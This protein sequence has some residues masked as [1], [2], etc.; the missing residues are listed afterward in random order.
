MNEIAFEEAHNWM[1]KVELSSKKGYSFDPNKDML[2]ITFTVICKA[3]FE[4]IPSEIEFSQFC[5]SLDI[6]LREFV[7]KQQINPFRRGLKYFI[8]EVRKALCHCQR[9]QGLAKR[10][11]DAYDEKPANERSLNKTLIRLIA[12]NDYLTPRDRIAEVVTFLIAGMDTT[13]CT[14]AS[15][16]VLLA[17]NPHVADKL[18]AELEACDPKEWSQC[19]YF[20]H[21]LQ[22]SYRIMPV[23]ALGPTRKVDRDHVYDGGVIPKGSLVY[24]PIILQ[25]YNEHVFPNPHTFFPERWSEDETTDPVKMSAMKDSVLPFSIGHRQCVGQPLAKAELQSLLPIFLSKYKFEVEKEGGLDFFLTLKYDNFKLI[26]R[27]S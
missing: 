3:A 17:K 24:L 23:S 12:E 18:R 15:T 2:Q 27:R 11:L 26:A 20:K 13:G 9:V 22:E 21:V 1:K 8:P 19:T 7:V 5:E 16:L 25:C 14:L 4:Y 10:I 6:C